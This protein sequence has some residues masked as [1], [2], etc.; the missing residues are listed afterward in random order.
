MQYDVEIN[1][2]T[3]QVAIRRV[4][5][6]FNA[7]VDGRSFEVDA[8]RIDPLTLSLVVR[9]SSG[10]AASNCSFEV[11]IVPDP[12]SGQLAIRVGSATVLVRRNGR[13][14]SGARDEGATAAVGPQRV[15]APMPGKIVRVL[16]QSGETVRARQPLVVVE[17]MK[18][19]NEL[20]AFR[21]GTVAEVL[22]REGQSVEAGTLLVVIQ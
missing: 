13:R 6:V 16:V 20:R 9:P 3:R 2:R 7:V 4:G 18:M 8:A 10:A 11:T 19:E 5:E 17:A 14:K 15:M 21:N 1:G 12:V 22:A